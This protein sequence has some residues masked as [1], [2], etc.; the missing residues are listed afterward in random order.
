MSKKILSSLIIVIGLGLGVFFS[1]Q[2]LSKPGVVKPPAPAPSQEVVPPAPETAPK[3]EVPAPLPAAPPETSLL[4][5]PGTPPAGKEVAPSAPL[6]PK[7]EQ[8]LLVGKFRR[9]TDAKRLLAKIQKQQIPAFIRKEGKYF[10][11]WA[12]PFPTPQEAEQAKKT[13]RAVC[14]VSPRQEKLETPVPK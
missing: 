8:G 2:F 13:L 12:G 6:E 3:P 11:V 1:Y 10:K 5:S 7:E 9:Y 14:K 4:P